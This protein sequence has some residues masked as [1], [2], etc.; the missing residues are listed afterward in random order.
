MNKLNISIT[1]VKVRGLNPY[2]IDEVV[3]LW[4]EASVEAHHFIPLDFWEGNKCAMATEYLP[5]SETIVALDANEIVGF[6]SMSENYLAAIFVKL[7]KQGM[8]TGKL[9]LNFIKSSRHSIQLKVYKKNIRSVE[10]YLK[11]G[12]KILSESIDKETGE[13]E[14]LMEWRSR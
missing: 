12:F 10:F 1:S 9:L 5:N 4:F 6:V 8:G 14:C 11:Q 3:D 13:M 2:E 7:Q